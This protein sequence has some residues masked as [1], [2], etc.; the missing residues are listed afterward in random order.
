MLELY[1][2]LRVWRVDFLN[3]AT[4]DSPCNLCRSLTRLPVDMERKEGREKREEWTGIPVSWPS[5]N[6]SCGCVWRRAWSRRHPLVGEHPFWSHKVGFTVRAES[7]FG[8][9][10]GTEG[11][12]WL[13][14]CATMAGNNFMDTF[15]QNLTKFEQIF[16][17]IYT[18]KKFDPLAQGVNLVLLSVQTASCSQ[19]F[20]NHYWRSLLAKP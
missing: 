11:E 19:S 10:G 1:L 3:V 6:H 9:V 16:A 13:E 14:R 15:T 20:C 2:F 5:W 7:I 18:N 17:A 4:G 8:R 12:P